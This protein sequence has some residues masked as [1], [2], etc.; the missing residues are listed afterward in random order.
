MYQ[1]F[2][3]VIL[4]LLFFRE[5]ELN[6][7]NFSWIFI[8]VSFVYLGEVSEKF[9]QKKIN[10]NNI[11]NF[12]DL[13]DFE[14][15]LHKDNDLQRRNNENELSSDLRLIE[16]KDN[17]I[18]VPSN[19]S[20][21]NPPNSNPNTPYSNNIINSYA[22]VDRDYLFNPMNIEKKSESSQNNIKN[23]QNQES[24]LHKSNLKESMCSNYEND[25]DNE[26]NKLSSKNTINHVNFIEP[27][28]TNL[29][30][31]KDDSF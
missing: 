16:N 6:I 27:I 13:N 11:E 31:K 18:P 20:I 22:R 12:R 9:Y 29:S 24:L 28:S 19:F 10:K 2:I 5:I 30:N 7:Y 23:N 1:L 25:E 15:D 26:N 17:D 14:L 3:V 8:I 4:L 21:G